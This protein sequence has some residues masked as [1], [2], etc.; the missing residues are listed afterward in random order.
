RDGVRVLEAT[1]VRGLRFRAMFIAG[2]NEGSFPLRTS[3]DWLYPH[4]ERERLKKHVVILEDISTETLMKEEHYFYQCACRAPERLYLPR[5]LAAD[6]GI[7]T[8]ASYYIEEL[9]RAFPPDEID[10]GQ[11]RGDISRQDIRHASNG[12]EL[13]R[14]LIAQKARQGHRRRGDH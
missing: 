1:D 11:V 8:V 7:E 4:E 14:K 5:P 3:H 12:S 2:M 13:A 6:D 9:R 10:E